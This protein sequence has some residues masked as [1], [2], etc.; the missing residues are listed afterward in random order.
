MGMNRVESVCVRETRG[1]V[2]GLRERL[3]AL[4]TE[5]VESTGQAVVV[6]PEVGL[7]PWTGV[8][9][10]LGPT[11]RLAGPVVLSEL[12]WMIMAVVDTV[13]VGPLG[14]SAIGAVGLANVL[15]FAVA[16]SGY[17]LMLGLDPLVS[18]AFGAGKLKECHLW[19]VH[20]LWASLLVTP[21]FMGLIL[22]G[23][24]MIGR[25]G[26]DPEV[27]R[28]SGP[29]LAALSWSILP[30]LAFTAC[31]RYLQGMN[32][33][34]PIMFA[35]VS[36]NLV[37][38]AANWVLI[39]GKFGL[40]ALGVVG[41]GWSTVIGRFWMLLVLL[42]A[43]WRSNGREGWRL[44]AIDW[45]PRS[46]LMKELLAMGLPVAAHVTFEVGVFAIAAAWAGRFG[47]AA[48][49]AHEVVLQAASVTFM[50]P[51]GISTAG[52]VRVG[53]ALGRG[54]PPGASR[55][56]WAALALGAGFMTCAGLAFVLIPRS[57]MG[58]F[59]SDAGV[60]STGVV[61]LLV[62]AV[63]QLFDGLQVVAAGALRG[64][65]DTK[66]PMYCSIF[67][68]WVMGLPMGW[69]LSFR[70]GMGI[71]GVWIGLCVGLV[72]AGLILMWVW[73]RTARR[74][75]ASSMASMEPNRV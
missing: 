39:H 47:S 48:L 52:S 35:L 19:L 57:I 7:S 16:V 43:I 13:M 12:G 10:E 6:E 44:F 2:P 53:Q 74:L 55:A 17:G 42:G 40:P 67:A 75:D 15:F 5:T 25:L 23:I 11:V 62:A 64:T 22:L 14:P 34:R 65:G 4:R 68:Y 59:T 73:V 38:L 60:M 1:G 32:I 56:G 26:I 69:A 20:G 41:S 58:V 61:L 37:N 24:P 36:A 45:R 70:F 46:K 27:V 31:R 33:V 72:S 51:F 30:I 71:L 63:F 66:T 50:V 3:E 21:L 8:V 54:D 18:Q 29:Y 28:L 9:R 49:A